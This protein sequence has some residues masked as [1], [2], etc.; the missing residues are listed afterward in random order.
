M[1]EYIQAGFLHVIPF[2]Y[3]HLL[4]MVVLYMSSNTLRDAI[5]KCTIFTL[6]HSITLL[7]AGMGWVSTC[8]RVVEPLVAF[9]IFIVAANNLHP[10]LSS[11]SGSA[12]VFVFGLV[13]GLGF[14]GALSD[15]GISGTE[16][17]L[18]LLCFN[19]GVEG[20]QLAV[21]TV[22]FFLF[23]RLLSRL[24]SY[25]QWI[26]KSVNFGIASMALFWTMERLIS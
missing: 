3:D 16:L 4:F 21:L 25:Q 24:A 7:M 17:P 19:I 20:A 1:Q 23:R 9:S 11:H 10:V 14:A 15:S 26:F 2:G 18:D 5:V 13:H 8:S 22:C 12:M 6:S